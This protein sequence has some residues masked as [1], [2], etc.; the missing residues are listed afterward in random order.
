MKRISVI[1][2]VTILAV[3][4]LIR[5]E[6][7]AKE[8]VEKEPAKDKPVVEAV[9]EH[10]LSEMGNVEYKPPT[11][12]NMAKLPP[13]QIEPPDVVQIEVSRKDGSSVIKGAYL[14]GPNGNVHL[15]KY[16]SVNILDKT[17]AQAKETLVKHLAGKVESPSVHVEVAARNSKVYY[18]ITK[19]DKSK[20]EKGDSVVRLPCTGKETVRDV[21]KQFPEIL[22]A[23]FVR[24]ERRILTLSIP[25]QVGL[26]VNVQAIRD[27]SAEHNY[28]ILPGDRLFVDSR[29]PK[30]YVALPPQVTKNSTTNKASQKHPKAT[31]PQYKVHASLTQTDADG[32]KKVLAEPTL[33]V[34]EG[35]QGFFNVGDKPRIMFPENSNTVP[36]EGKTFQCTI[37]KHLHKIYLDGTFRHTVVQKNDSDGMCLAGSDLRIIRPVELGKKFAVLLPDPDEKGTRSSLE[38]MVERVEAASVAK[39]LKKSKVLK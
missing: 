6:L 4:C 30:K 22:S 15:K 25:C 12:A 38:I 16:G 17:A 13:Y 19:A 39:D 31:T 35:V 3:F 5:V 2:T 21:M 26:G 36:I 28:Q 11:E 1:G 18:I 7:V 27:G 10:P 29:V 14:V 23:K 32:R 37:S 34:P 33:I 8:P 24:I 9:I 20:G